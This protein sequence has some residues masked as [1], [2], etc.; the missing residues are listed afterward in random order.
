MCSRP[1]AHVPGGAEKIVHD[2]FHMMKHMN[3]AVNEVRKTEHRALSAEGDRHAGRNAVA[4][5]LR[6]GETSPRRNGLHLM[7]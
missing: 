7:C 1:G 2:P 4:L 3:D 6:R 5:A